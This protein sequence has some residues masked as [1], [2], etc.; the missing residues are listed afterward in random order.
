MN[1]F[2]ELKIWQFAFKLAKDI[3]ILTKEFPQDE[4]Y[5]MVSQIR[6][7]STSIPANIAEGAGRNSNKEFI[8]FLA[9]AIGSA[10][11]LETFI[12]LAF[13]V[14]YISKEEMESIVNR[15]K[16]IIRMNMKL[17]EALKKQN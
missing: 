5:G 12:L 10:Y 3:Y 7:A 14:N 17:Q 6:R 2:K 16:L 1:N 11:E 15:N 9:I 13:E 8:Q 4:K